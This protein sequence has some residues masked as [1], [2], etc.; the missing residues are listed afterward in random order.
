M[1]LL[2]YFPNGPILLLDIKT[3]LLIKSRIV[4]WLCKESLKV[5]LSEA[6]SDSTFSSLN[7]VLLG[8]PHYK[9]VIDLEYILHPGGWY[10]SLQHIIFKLKSQLCL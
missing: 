9:R 7:P 1:K 5:M 8:I 4:E 2:L 3:S 10:Q 6:I